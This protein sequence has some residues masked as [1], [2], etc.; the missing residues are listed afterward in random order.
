MYVLW[1]YESSSDYILSRNATYNTLFMFKYTKKDPSVLFSAHFRRLVWKAWAVC[2]S[3]LSQRLVLRAELR[4]IIHLRSQTF[5][6]INSNFCRENVKT[7]YPRPDNNSSIRSS[8]NIK[9]ANVG[10]SFF[11]ILTISLIG[12]DHNYIIFA[13]YTNN[14]MINYVH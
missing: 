9:L 14:I 6:N 4:W 2:Q 5:R 3:Q 7:Y 11:H 13:C 10:W 8:R 12:D 1:D